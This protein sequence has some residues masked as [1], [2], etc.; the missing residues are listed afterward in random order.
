[1]TAPEIESNGLSRSQLTRSTAIWPLFALGALLLLNAFALPS[2][3]E[4]EFLDGNLYGSLVDVLNRSSIGVVLAVGMTLV[5]ATGGVD[6]SV[7]S[8]L[9]IT[10]TVAATLMAKTELGVTTAVL[11][12]IAVAMLAGALNGLLVTSLKIEPVIATLV[13]MV[14]GRGIAKYIAGE[15]VIS[16]P[17]DE[18]FAAFDWIGNGHLF[19]L[20]VPTLLALSLALVTFFVVRKTS[21][22]LLIESVGGNA[23]ASRATGIND[24]MVKLFVYVFAAFCAGVA[25][26]IDTAYINA[27]DPVNAGVFTELDAIFAV[28]VGGTALTGGRFSLTGSIVGAILLQTLLTT[29]YAYGVASDVAPVPKAGVILIVCLLQSTKVRTWFRKRARGQQ[30]N[31]ATAFSSPADS[32]SEEAS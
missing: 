21:I 12:S 22:G 30:G 26:L 2:F 23:A 25:G 19:G 31:P 14:S 5:I 17:R 8:V 7:G 4:L 24:R 32:S 11:I 29:M 27:S 6:L 1:M 20:P 10:G 16:V 13:L 3:F 18:A 28:L 15:Q 9:A